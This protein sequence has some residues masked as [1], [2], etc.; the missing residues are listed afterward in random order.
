MGSADGGTGASLTVRS[1]GGAFGGSRR[2]WCGPPRK[3]MGSAKGVVSTR[4]SDT[5][6]GRRF[7]IEFKYEDAPRATPSMRI[8]REDLG[9]ARLW[10]VYPGERSYDLAE[11]VNVVPLSQLPAV[12][13][14][15]KLR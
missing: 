1:S 6:S 12:L 7:G 2:T 3:G 8:A 4:D 15:A 13:R 9:L 14:A 5:A 11:W 10:V